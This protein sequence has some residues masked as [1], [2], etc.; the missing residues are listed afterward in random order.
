MKLPI[1]TPLGAL[2]A[3]HG[4][5]VVKPLAAFVQHGM[6]GH[7]PHNARSVLRPQGQR[8]TVEFVF[9]R[10]HLF[11]NNVSHLAQSAHEQ[12]RRFNNRRADVSVSVARHQRANFFFQ[13][14]PA[15]RIRR[16]DV[17]HAL[18]GN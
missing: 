15:R 6:L 14:F 10:V 13:P 8:F 11:F 1:A 12:W 17:V 16:Q 7:R 9:K 3:K 4:A 18:H 5:H 2:V